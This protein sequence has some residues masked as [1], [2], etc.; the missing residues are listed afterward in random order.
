MTPAIFKSIRTQAG[1]TQR[2]LAERLRVGARHIRSIEA[3]DR[4]PSGPLTVL[5]EQIEQEQSL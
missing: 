3:G 2:Q 5:M 4:E 1:L